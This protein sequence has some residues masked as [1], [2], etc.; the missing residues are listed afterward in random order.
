MHK[1]MIIPFRCPHSV[2]IVA[3]NSYIVMVN[4]AEDV[5]VCSS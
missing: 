2:G 5:M 4:A 3:S 1:W